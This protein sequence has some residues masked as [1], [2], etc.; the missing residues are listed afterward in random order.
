MNSFYFQA[1]RVWPWAWTFCWSF[2][3]VSHHFP[4][5]LSIW[6]GQERSKLLHADSMSILVWPCLA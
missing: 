5:K 2:V 4:T 1:K 3:R 6:R